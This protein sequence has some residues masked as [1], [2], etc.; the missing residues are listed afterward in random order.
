[1]SQLEFNNYLRAY[2]LADINLYKNQNE[3][4]RCPEKDES[5]VAQ[6]QQRLVPKYINEK[7]PFRGLLVWHGL[8]S[9]KS[10][11]AILT[12]NGFKTK[13]KV[14]VVP[15]SLVNNFKGDYSRVCGPLVSQEP[16]LQKEILKQTFSKFSREE[17]ET[18]PFT[19]YTS[20]GNI[21]S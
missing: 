8:G 14:V 13:E 18:K 10:C 1:M 11:T 16:E 19:T 2:Y 15:A 4:A 17:T 3:T 6:A 9:G 21:N 7:T 12:A 5:F 20:N